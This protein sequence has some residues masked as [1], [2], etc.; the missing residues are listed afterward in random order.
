MNGLAAAAVVLFGLELPPQPAA[1]A[2]AAPARTT[3]A[4]ILRA[5][6]SFSPPLVFATV[7]RKLPGESTTAAPAHVALAVVLQVRGGELQVLLWERARAPFAGRW[8]LPGGYREE[9]ETLEASIRRHLA[10]K[11]AVRAPALA[12][13]ARWRARPAERAPP[14]GAPAAAGPE[15]RPSGIALPLPPATAR[16]HR[17]L[18]GAAPTALR[19]AGRTSR[20]PSNVPPPCAL[21]SRAL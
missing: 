5:V 16:N 10:A 15:R 9:G 2:A 13:A 18:R 4:P 21:S 12:D 7:K 14:G 6:T 17:P 8:A 19:I 3:A 11:A 1:R 20:L